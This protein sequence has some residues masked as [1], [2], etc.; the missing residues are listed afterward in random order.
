MVDSSS[1]IGPRIGPT[2]APSR[3]APEARRQDSVPEDNPEAPVSIA[4]P[5]GR[6]VESLLASDSPPPRGSLLN[7]LVLA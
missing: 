6:D 7:I 3:P 2:P 4:E 1:S 5:Q